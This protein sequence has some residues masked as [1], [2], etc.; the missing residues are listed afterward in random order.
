MIGLIKIEQSGN[1]DNITRFLETMKKRDVMSVLNRYGQIGVDRLREATPVDSG[2]T[3]ESW[4]YEIVANNSQYRLY[5]TNTNENNGVHIAIILQYGHGTKNGG[6]VEGTDY[7][8][9]VLEEIFKTM[10][11]ELWKEVVNA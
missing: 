1:F 10:A 7:I 2:K 4:G 3:A 8:N 6:F 5:W 9:P 11:E